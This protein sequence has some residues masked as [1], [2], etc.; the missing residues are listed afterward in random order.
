MEHLEK[1]KTRQEIADE[2]KISRWTLDRWL[3]KAGIDLSSGLISPKEQQLVY[4]RFGYPNK[5]PRKSPSGI[6]KG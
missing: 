5:E 4:E 2:Y 1:A 3:K 6:W